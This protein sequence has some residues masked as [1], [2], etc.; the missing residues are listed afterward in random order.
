MD[1]TE[2]CRTWKRP[3]S[4]EATAT[5]VDGPALSAV[6]RGPH[7]ISLSTVRHEFEPAANSTIGTAHTTYR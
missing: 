7:W 1:Q 4:G 6:G 5:V 3:T 2:T